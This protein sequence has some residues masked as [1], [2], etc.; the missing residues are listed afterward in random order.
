[1]F[2]AWSIGTSMTDGPSSASARR[3]MSAKSAACSTRHAGSPKERAYC[4][5][6]GL[7]E[8]HAK[9]PAETALLVHFDQTVAVV[10]P[11]DI[12][13]GHAQSLRS[14]Q[15]LRVH[16][17]A[18]I[19]ADCHDFALRLGQLGGQ[20]AGD[21]D[22]H[23]GETVGDDGRIG[24]AARVVERQP[25]LVRAHIADQDVVVG[26]GL[27]QI[28]DHALRFHGQA[29]VVRIP[30]QVAERSRCATGRGRV[31][32]PGVCPPRLRPGRAE[33]RQRA[34]GR[35]RFRPPLRPRADSGRQFRRACCPR[36]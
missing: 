15:L 28:P 10:A 27:A 36:G 3:S 18:P 23:R 14:L 9:G 29:L 13:V 34:A 21:G 19:A 12:D 33:G 35:R 1:M 25:Q 26:Q 11:D 32:P 22:A 7:G 6:S 5:M 2:S 16:Q 31:S 8:L 17:E 24:P 20:P 4:A 30:L